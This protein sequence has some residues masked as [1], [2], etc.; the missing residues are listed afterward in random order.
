[1][2]NRFFAPLPVPYEGW[3]HRETKWGFEM[4]ELDDKF[5]I[6]AEAPG[7]EGNEFEVFVNGNILMLKAEHKVLDEEKK[8]GS[9][10]C[11]RSWEED[12]TLPVGVKPEGIE[13]F[14]KNGILEL[15]V[16]KLEEVKPRRIT[17][18]T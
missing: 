5:V 9:Y 10:R 7:F 13:A 15:H 11:E 3:P 14:Y 12:V 2:F 6:H 8:D 18:K 4:E 17:V 16:P 1:M